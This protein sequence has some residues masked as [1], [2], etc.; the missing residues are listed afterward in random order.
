MADP[1]PASFRAN[2]VIGRTIAGKFRVTSYLGGGAVGAVYKARQLALDKDVAIKLLHG[3]H[4]G[5]TMFAARFQREAKAASRLDHPNSM[6]VLDFGVEPDGVAYIAMEYLDGRH[7][8]GVMDE[9]W[10]L[11][12]PR[13]ADIV[14]QAL[15]AVGAADAMGIVHRD[16]KPENIMVLRGTDDEGEPRDVV[17][18][19]DFGIAKFIEDRGA[20]ITG[21]EKLTQAGIVVGTPEY[22]SPEQCKAER[23]DV[24]SDLYSMGIILYQLLTGRVP[25]QADTALGIAL[26]QLNEEAPPPRTFNPEV[27]ERLEAV[28]VK[29]MKKKREQRYQTAREMRADLRAVVGTWAPEPLSQSTPIVVE[30]PGVPSVVPTNPWLTRQPPADEELEWETAAAEPTPDIPAA[31]PPPPPPPPSSPEAS[32][33][34]TP[35]PEMA[36]SMDATEAAASE[37]AGRRAADRTQRMPARETRGPQGTQRMKAR[38]ERGPTGTVLM[39]AREGRGPTGTV[40]MKGR[41]AGTASGRSW[42]VVAA[43]LGAI[44]LLAIACALTRG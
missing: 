16:L 41:A 14:A 34:V 10:P 3:E 11:P 43:V 27:D 32:V 8:L 44:V 26:K 17:K 38:E 29:A 42:L 13:V 30:G 33:I 9:D 22:M 37:R 39:K 21:D 2:A 20:P 12:P 24:R 28:C 4:A 6:R 15:A 18:V 5:D 40:L 35:E 31:A 25:F 7:L 36:S 19:C 23:L 1:R